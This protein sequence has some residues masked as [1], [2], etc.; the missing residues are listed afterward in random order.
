MQAKWIK[1][2]QNF[3]EMSPEF[4]KSHS[5]R[6][7]VRRAY[8]KI[9]AMG[10]YDFYINGQKAGDGV[11]APGWTSY[12]TRVQA[13]TYDITALLTEETTFALRL[14]AGWAVGYMGYGHWDCIFTDHVSAWAEI[15]VEYADGGE[16]RIVTD[17]SWQVY[18]TPILSSQIYHG[19]TVDHTAEFRCVGNALEDT[20][21]HPEIVD[22]QG[23][24]IKE[25]ERIL[26]CEYIVTPNGE[27]VLD[28]GQNLAGYVEVKVSGKRGD[29]IVLSHAEV[30][31][32][33]GNFYTENLRSARNINTYILSGEGEEVFKP[34]FSFQGFRYI[35]LDE[36]PEEVEIRLENFTAI[37]IYSD[38]RRTGDFS[39]G[40]DKINQLYSNIIWGQRG[41]FID[42]PTDCPQRDE[43]L[44]WTGDAQV[45]CRT[46]AINYDVERFFDK[47]LTDMR[48][49]QRED[50]GVYGV[51]PLVQKNG[52][53]CGDRIATGWAD[54]AVI[55]PWEIYR[56]YGNK[57]MLGKN[58]DMMKKWVG[59]MHAFGEEEYLFLG[60]RHYGDWLATDAGYGICEGAT[61]TDL[62]A[63]AYFA[64]STGMVVKIG[65]ILGE[66]VSE[67]EDLYQ[68]V[69]AAFRQAFMKD[70]MPT[71]YPKADALS[72]SRPVKGLTQTSLILVLRFGL[73]EENER[74]ALVDKLVELIAE[75]DGRMTTGFLGTPNILHALHEN[76]RTDVAYDLLF[77]EKAPSWLFSV[78]Q[79]A[80]TIWEHWDSIREDGSFWSKSMN[81]FNH[82]AYGSV[83]DWIFGV[84]L[85]IDVD[86]DGAGYEKITVTPH[87]DRRLGFAKGSVESRQGKIQVYWRYVGDRVRYEITVPAGT[88]AK[89]RLP[90]K[91]PV[92]FSAGT[93]I[94]VV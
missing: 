12:G 33:D 83:F 52:H 40:N 58:F 74:Q 23:E 93:Y 78:N 50:G 14:G 55:C 21:P 45:F 8:A 31:D 47:W 27:K 48:I 80:T 85:G 87:P 72:T 3:G 46:A 37:V 22:L 53:I 76:G 1:T 41:N 9:T 32:K 19:E 15:T 29:R 11:L 38:M 36:F 5:L 43:R 13:Q 7:A 20:S 75:N 64:F 28:F 68:K 77:Q 84:T 57:D 39:C 86:E 24:E 90:G 66:D 92:F 16:D 6:G 82:Y 61:Q 51:I 71:L 65:K 42:V 2:E 91:D 30:L 25:H 10:V 94:S 63:S 70:G 49:E 18:T 62:I 56:A 26:A 73:Y 54:A 4:R 35:R 88:Q 17:A 44:G 60:A 81:S 89:I 67:Y 79:G 34:S 59:Y 69:R